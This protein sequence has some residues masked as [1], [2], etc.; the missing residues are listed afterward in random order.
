[1]VEVA[2]P[3]HHITKTSF[4]VLHNSSYSFN[5]TWRYYNHQ[6]TRTCASK[7][8]AMRK[9][10]C[11]TCG[12]T[13]CIQ[14]RTLSAGQYVSSDRCRESN[15]NPD[16]TGLSKDEERLVM[17][18]RSNQSRCWARKTKLATKKGKVAT[19][20]N[21]KCAWPPLICALVN[22]M[23]RSHWPRHHLRCQQAWT[24]WIN[25]LDRGNLCCHFF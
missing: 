24:L 1:M 18:K 19:L 20:A 17:H 7:L 9:V 3:L 23:K 14:V 16:I 6:H 4:D 13:L 2:T 22:Q 25:Q 8:Q 21:C 15:I 12:D 10:L 5:I 11:K